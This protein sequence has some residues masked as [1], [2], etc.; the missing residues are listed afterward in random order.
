MAVAISSSSTLASFTGIKST[1]QL[2]VSQSVSELVTRVDNDQTL[3]DKRYMYVLWI[4]CD[5][6]C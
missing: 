6:D 1:K 2:S 3:V 5:I 4:R